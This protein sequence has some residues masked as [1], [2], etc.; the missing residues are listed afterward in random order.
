MKT[1]LTL[2]LLSTTLFAA[3]AAP[4]MRADPPIQCD[5]CA[6][7]NAPRAP[8]RVFGNTYF[9]G[10]AGLG[11]VLVTSD[12]GHVLL[13]GALPQSAPLIDANIRALGFR[14]E[15]VRVIVN[16]HAHFDHAGGIA[17]LQR[18][19]GAAVAASAAGARALERGGPVPEDPQFVGGTTFPRVTKVRVVADGE[20]LRVGPLA[21][22][23]HVTPGHTPG[24]TSWT[25]RSC[26]NG[27]CL[28][29]V[30]AD[31]L[32]A[33]SAPGFRFSGDATHPSL[34]DAFRR[35]IA[36]VEG[37]PCDILLAVHP[38]FADMDRKLAARAQ[39]AASDPFLDP[40]ACRVY[41]ASARQ[42]LERRL[43]QE[44]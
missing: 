19:S 31:S 7:W 36:T 27:R 14:T 24:S 13:D 43:Q 26:D 34:V 37:L 23:A 29:V 33:V 32:N 5:S 38:G 17:A 3:P 4:K 30:Y 20:T 18:A 25:W 8:F 41:A 28:D 22:T 21:V 35:T 2:A 10:P 9:V 11:S 6:E 16:S 1:T 44:K 42:A 12:A 15:D 40:G 39:G